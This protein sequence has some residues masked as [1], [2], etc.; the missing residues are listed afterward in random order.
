MQSHE[1]IQ[2]KFRRELGEE[3]YAALHNPSVTELMLNEDG[4]V[5]LDTWDGMI[6]YSKLMPLQAHNVIRTLASLSGVE[7]HR[8]SPD[9]AAELNLLMEGGEMKTFR[10]QGVVPPIVSQPVFAIRKPASR[11][12]TLADYEARGMMAPAQ[13]SYIE[14]AVALRKNIL[15]VGGTGSGKTTL[16]NAILQ[17]VAQRFPKDR[18]A[19]IE[20]TLELQ[21]AVANK[22]QFRSCETRSMNDLLRVCM[23]LRPDRIVMG[24]VRGKEAHALIKAWNTGH[25]GGLS[26][27]HANDALRGLMRLGQLIEEAGVPAVG[28]AIAEAVEQVIFIARDASLPAGRRVME[29]LSVTGYD[30]ATHRYSYELLSSGIE[31]R[32]CS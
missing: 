9:I 20:D 19:I 17:E 7:V 28:E 1:R 4:K 30:R 23:R 31:P 10:F 22:L 2:D 8:Q 27:L 29:I 14:Q 26:T 5:W 16:C 32:P 18:I 21:C 12:F 6:E 11:I 25:P 3:L 13:R 24:E 15:V